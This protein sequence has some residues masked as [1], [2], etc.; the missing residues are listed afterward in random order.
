MLASGIFKIITNLVENS[1]IHGYSNGEK[2][3]ISIDIKANESTLNI[4]DGKGIET[5]DLDKIFHPFYTTKRGDGCIGL[6]RHFAGIIFAFPTICN[7]QLLASNF[8]QTNSLYH[9]FT[10]LAFQTGKYC[11]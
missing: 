5:S 7:K 8:I 1:I 2:G 10:K 9:T 6:W 11:C 4:L 3:P